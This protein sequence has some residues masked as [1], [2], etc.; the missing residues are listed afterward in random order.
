M[1][2][3]KDR[4]RSDALLPIVCSQLN[5]T[6]GN[7]TCT[8]ADD[9]K[10][11]KQ[12]TDIVFKTGTADLDIAVRLR[13]KKYYETNSGEFTLRDKRPNT[14][15][16][17]LKKILSGYGDYLFYGFMSEAEHK[18]MYYNILNL[19]VFRKW[20]AMKSTELKNGAYYISQTPGF[21]Q[22]N[23]DGSSSFV[24]FR[25]EEIQGYNDKF[26]VQNYCD[27]IF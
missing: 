18:I 27:D 19:D 26:I 13:S 12:A 6:F 17:E 25:I 21:I 1:E 9:F 14:D 16:S 15:E 3:I 5:K 22:N 10:D 20:Y 11:M 23:A 7:G 2:Y 4:I 8:V 24:C